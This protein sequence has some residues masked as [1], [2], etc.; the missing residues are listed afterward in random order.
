MITYY[1]HSLCKQPAA[2]ITLMENNRGPPGTPSSPS[3]GSPHT[4]LVMISSQRRRHHLHQPHVKSADP[5]MVMVLW[6]CQ[7]LDPKLVMVW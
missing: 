2:L 1:A 7:T 5:V 6:S 3:P 4:P